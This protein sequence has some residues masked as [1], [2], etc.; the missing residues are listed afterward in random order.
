MFKNHFRTMPSKPE[1]VIR[2]ATSA[3]VESLTSIIPRSYPPDSWM[4]KIFKDGPTMHQWWTE[5]YNRALQDP[6]YRILVALDGTLVVGVFTLALWR[7]SA[8]M[9]EANSGLCTLVPL[10]ED[11]DEVLKDALV[12]QITD[13]RQKMGEQTNFMIDLVGVDRA[14]QSQGIGA[15]LAKFACEIADQEKAAL[16]LETGDAREWYMKLDL[17]FEVA[18]QSDEDGAGGVVIRQPR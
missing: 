9:P 8:A 6:S 11:H 14:Y 1:I 7:K 10:T 2:D 18:K 16:F 3:E 12:E 5:V 13:R 17:G 15:R 4:H